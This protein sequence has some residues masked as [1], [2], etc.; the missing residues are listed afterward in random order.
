MKKQD[1]YLGLDI[2]TNSVGWAA[3]DPEYNMLKFKGEPM[4]GVHLFDEAKPASDRRAFR[5]ARRRLDRRQQRV[6]L[7]QE[8]FSHEIAKVDPRFYIRLQESA[9]YRKPDGFEYPLFNDKDYT[10]KEYYAQYP[11]IHHLICD[12]MD[13]TNPHDV[14]LV[15]LAC[16]WLVAHRGH[17]LSMV[18]TANI[19]AV[20]AFD[21]VYRNFE[22][23]FEDN[24]YD[25]P[26][27]SEYAEQIREILSGERGISRKLS[28]LKNVLFGGKSP[29]K[30]PESAFGKEAIMKLFPQIFKWI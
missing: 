2:G 13:S 29:S 25:L 30:N 1:Y 18:N 17:F 20:T 28:A 9:L 26:W 3:T 16:A 27:S 4:W 10:D 11:T 5:T 22:D 14:R 23:Y 12:L 21:V 8:I 24:G 15:Y 19:A 6:D 7:V